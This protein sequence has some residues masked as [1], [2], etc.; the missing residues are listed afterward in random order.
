MTIN[1]ATATITRPGTSTKRSFVARL[2][3]RFNVKD[4]GAM[5]DY[6]ETTNPT[7]DDTAAIQAA[8]NAAVAQSGGTVYFPAGRYRLTSRLVMPTSGAPCLTLLGDGASCADNMGSIIEGNFQDYLIV[9][10]GRSNSIKYIRGLGF[11]NTNSH[12]PASA[13]PPNHLDIRTTI[14]NTSVGTSGRVRLNVIQNY[15]QIGP[16]AGG[17]GRAGAYHVGQSI[18]ITGVVGGTPGVNGL[19]TVTASFGD[20]V[21]VPEGTEG[22]WIE[23]DVL[24]TAVGTGG[25]VIFN[26]DGCGCIYWKFPSTVMESCD[27]VFGDP[28]AGTGCTALSLTALVNRIVSTSFTGPW[29]PGQS[30]NSSFGILGRSLTVES[31]TFQNIG[32][33]ISIWIGPVGCHHSILKKCS[34]GFYV[35]DNPVSYLEDESGIH[36][37]GSN[38]Q[39][40]ASLRATLMEDMAQYFAY[41]TNGSISMSGSVMTSSGG[42]IGVPISGIY[43]SSSVNLEASSIT[44]VFS[45]SALNFQG[46]THQGGNLTAFN[47]TASGGGVPYK[48]PNSWENNSRPF[49]FR[50]CP[51]QDGGDITSN[52]NNKQISVTSYDTVVCTNSSVPTWTG[53]VSNAGKVLAGGG[54]DRVMARWKVIGSLAATS[55]W[56]I[57]PNDTSSVIT[58]TANPGMFA[59][60]M[61]VNDPATNSVLGTVQSFPTSS[62]TL[63]LTAPAAWYSSADPAQKRMTAADVVAGGSGYAVG[64]T[65]SVGNGSVLTVA[66]IT[67]SAI[68]TVTVTNPGNIIAT[69]SIPANPVAATTLTG[70]GSGASFNLTWD[71]VLGTSTSD[72][73]VFSAYVIAG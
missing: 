67:G 13:E 24:H 63:T 3:T 43:S 73:L 69:T 22:A 6:N 42:S 31:C 72:V 27:L 52:F 30:I 40:S 12:V 14:V 57:Y 56:G 5:G 60:G 58:M 51:G 47:A 33:A 15:H 61:S 48:L 35:G 17:S 37:A 54:S 28:V 2:G 11:R 7:R 44:G 59:A 26:G 19:Q 36:D 23:I 29:K 34:V 38:Q 71:V 53:S 25:T 16:V 9:T 20:F 62:T 10:S 32:K 65:V 55:N 8:L 45:D 68:A 4:F 21:Q 70:T 64:N 39:G 50:N 66:T 46:H 18:I 49:T 41:V 1:L